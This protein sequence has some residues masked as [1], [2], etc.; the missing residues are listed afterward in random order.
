MWDLIAPP[1]GRPSVSMLFCKLMD[2]IAKP[3]PIK[4]VW[5]GELFCLNIVPDW[6]RVWSNL[7]LISKHLAHRLIHFKVIHRAYITPYKRFKMK[8]QTTYNCHICNSTL[9]G[10]F[11]HMFW[12][13]SIV[14]S[15]LSSL[16]HIDY[17]PNPGLCLLNND[18]D[19]DELIQK[20]ILFAGFTSA[21]KNNNT[22][23]VHA[24]DG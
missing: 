4:S 7:S 6:E 16:L 24:T 5:N 19:L 1:S 12:E 10:T 13:C 14:Q 17:N 22:E 21:K 11:L 23:L 15:T 8:L 3:L 20:K 2:W 18:S 9:S